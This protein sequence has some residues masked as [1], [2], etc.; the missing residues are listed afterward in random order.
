MTSHYSSSSPGS[1][2]V[3][4]L[5]A[6]TPLPPD[7]NTRSLGNIS[8]ATEHS[9]TSIRNDFGDINDHTRTT[10]ETNIH[11]TLHAGSIALGSRQVTGSELSVTT[12]PSG[13]LELDSPGEGSSAEDE[14]W[15]AAVEFTATRE[16]TWTEL[17]H[18]RDFILW[19]RVPLSVIGGTLIPVIIVQAWECAVA[20]CL[21]SLV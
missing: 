8:R 17:A 4:H 12:R 20:G 14:H 18:W 5:S 21:A 6:F 15:V 10:S 9:Q 16:S 19:V 1:R 7:D 13:L 2:S 11:A 3:H